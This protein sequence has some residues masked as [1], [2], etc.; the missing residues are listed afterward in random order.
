MRSPFIDVAISWSGGY[1]RRCHAQ[2][3]GFE[4]HRV[5]RNFVP[6]ANTQRSRVQYLVIAKKNQLFRFRLCP[7]LA[8]DPVI[9]LFSQLNPAHRGRAKFP[10]IVDLA[11]ITASS[12]KAPAELKIFLILGSDL[13]Q[14]LNPAN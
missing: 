10:E 2:G 11:R 14:T 9:N 7:C 1:A 8:G 3:H 13:S 5:H 6:V 12:A 4:P